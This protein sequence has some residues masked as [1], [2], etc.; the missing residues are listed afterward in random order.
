MKISRLVHV[1][2]A[3]AWLCTLLPVAAQVLPTGGYL[4][5]LKAAEAATAAL[6][7]NAWDAARSPQK[8]ATLRPFSSALQSLGTQRAFVGDTAGAIAAFDILGS[9]PRK[10]SAADAARVDEADVEDAVQAIVAQA[11]TRR[12]VLL[13]EAHHMPMHR[14]FSQRVARE[15]RKIGYT[16]LACEAFVAY[17]GSAP[18]VFDKSYIDQRG[19]YTLDP[20]FGEWMTEAKADGWKLVSYESGRRDEAMPPEQRLLA[21]EE[22]QARNLVERIFAR[23]KH[24]KVLIHAGYG[25]LYKGTI[26][27]PSGTELL[28]MGEHLRRMTGL[29]I[30]HVDQTQFYAH[31]DAIDDS[32]LYARMLAKPGTAAP[33]VLKSKQ[34]EYA[35]LQGMKERVD[36]Q[37]VFPRYAFSDANGRPA[38]LASLAGRTP[39]AIPAALLPASGR[40]AVLAYRAGEPDDAVPADVVLAEAGKPAPKLMLPAGEFRFA[41]EE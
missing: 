16:Y 1:C 31:P 26:K 40:R 6:P 10:E 28:M 32:A 39:R 13:N 4:Q 38:W 15:L 27:L 5:R 23:D 33:F 37:V 34:G 25:H 3:V 35:V 20:V 12:I 22:E 2:G 30:L 29:D 18:P 11:R 7:A 19:Y 41:V 8:L 17:V 14:A 21:R 24:A 9:G 36:M